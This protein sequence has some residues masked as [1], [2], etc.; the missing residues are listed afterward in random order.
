MIDDDWKVV[1]AG[2][3]LKVDEEFNGRRYSSIKFPIP[4]GD[5]TL[6]AGFTMDMTEIMQNQEALARGQGSGRGCQSGQ[7]RVFGQHEP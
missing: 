1:S 4:Q 5:R 2:Q 3:V 7:V 6:L